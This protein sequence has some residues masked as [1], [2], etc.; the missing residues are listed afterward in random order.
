MAGRG[1]RVWAGRVAGVLAAVLAVSSVQAVVSTTGT[2]PASKASAAPAPEP[3][4][5]RPDEASAVL[6]A[7]HEGHRVEVT[8]ERTESS[9]VFANPDGTL[10]AEVASGP[11]RVRQGDSWAPVDTTL[12]VSGGQVVAAAVP[13]GLS[14]STGGSGPV[15]SLSRAGKAFGLTWPGSLGAPVVKGNTATYPDVAPGTDLVVSVLPSGVEVSF[16]LRTRP[17]GPVSLGFGVTSP[18]LTVGV[19]ASGGFTAKDDGGAVV[20]GGPPPAM[21]GADADRAA[22]SAG[23]VRPVDQEL[24]TSLSGT[25]VT[26]TPDWGFLSDPSTVYPVTVDPL[27]GFSFFWDTFVW[28]GASGTNFEGSQ[29]FR[30]GSPDG[31]TTQRALLRFGLP[32]SLTGAH[33]LDADLRVYQEQAGSCT[34]TTANVRMIGASWNPSTVTWSSQPTVLPGVYDPTSF[35]HGFDASCASAWQDIH[36]PDVVNQWLNGGVTNNGLELWAGN[37][38]DASARKIFR[39]SE[40]GG[41]TTY[42]PALVATYNLY[43]GTVAGRSTEPSTIF[44]TT[45]YTTSA[46][47]T[48]R[49]GSVDGDG[50][51]TRVDY[52]IWNSTGTTKIA[53]GSTPFAQQGSLLGW[54]PATPLAD[55]AYEWRARG[56][57]GTD[58]SKNWSSWV[59]FTV[60]TVHPATPV[61][62]STDYT[63]GVWKGANP[64][65]TFTLSD[66]STDLDH[67]VYS[68]DRSTPSITTASP[69]VITPGDGWRT[70]SVQ[71]VDKAGNLSV[72]ATYSFGTIPGLTS[73]AKGT[74]TQGSLQLSS[75]AAPG[76][77]SV[78]YNW[79]RSPSDAWAPI[80]AADVTLGG[81]G[82]GSWPV[83]FSSGSGDSI[84][85]DLVWHVAASLSDQDGPVQVQVCFDTGCSAIPVDATLDEA[86][87][88]DAYATDG[89]GPGTLSLLTGNLAV[90]ETDVSVPAY[91]TTLTVGRTFNTRAPASPVSGV[92]GPGWTAA[93]PVDEAGS[94][95]SG[96]S[97]TGTAVTLTGSDGSITSFAKTGAT[98]TPTGDDADSGITLTASGGNANGPTTFTL[99]DLDG[100]STNFTAAS[101]ASPPSLTNP[102]SYAVA[103]VSQPGSNQTTTFTYDTSNRPTR[104]LAPIPPGGTCTDPASAATWT[105]GCRALTFGYDTNS[106]LTAVTLVTNPGSSVLQVD[107]ACYSYDGNG[108]LAQAW[109]P[110]DGAAG[111]GSHPVACGSPVLAT[112][113]GYDTGTGRLTTVTPP[114][115]AAW[116]LGYDGTGRVITAS[117]THNATFGG[118]T[119]T[120]TAVYGISIQADGTNPD[121][122]PG[123]LGADVAGWAQTDA[124]V[125][126]T[127]IYTPGDT[128]SATDLRDGQVHYLDVNGREVN[129]ASYSGTGATGWHI[130]TTEYGPTGNTLRSLTATNR[131]EAL[132]PTAG[133]GADLGLP[134]DTAAA[135]MALS[136]VNTYVTAADGTADLTDTWGPYHTVTLADGDHVGARAHTHNTYDTGSEVGHPVGPTLHLVTSTTTAASLSIDT[137][138]TDERDTR[139]TDTFYALSATD[140]TGWTFRQPMK[141]VEDPTGLAKTSITRYDATTGA[142]IESR[143]P[144]NT[145]G[146]GAG[147]TLSIY[148]TAG[149][150]TQDAACGNKPAWINLLCET[151]PAAQPGVAGLPGL[152]TSRTSTY[153]Y[154]NRSTQVDEIVTDAVGAT[155]TRT[156]TTTYLNSGYGDRVVTTTV[157]DGLGA[158]VPTTTTDYDPATG[159]AT[160]VSASAT[161]ENAATSATTGYDD[162]GRTITYVDADEAT[163]AARNQT[164]T[165]YDTAGRVHQV[166]DAHTTLTYTYNGGTE[167]RGLTTSLAVAV[168]SATP[169]TGTYTAV[170]DPDGQ[171]SSQTDPKGIRTDLVRDETGALNTLTAINTADGSTWMTDQI[172]GTTIHGQ[173]TGDAGPAGSHAY[174][175]DALGRLTQADDT[176][177]GATCI[178]RVY[179]FDADTN[180][181]TSTAYPAGTDGACQGDTGGVATT[182]TYDTAD[183]LQPAGVDTGLAYDAFGRTTT[184]PGYGGA[185]GTDPTTIDYYAGDLVR[186]ETQGATIR[187]WGLDADGRFG[188][189]T[190]TVSGSTTATKTNHYDDGS[191]DSPDWIAENADASQWTA[192]ISD[193]LS[194]LGLTVDQAG[195][196]T[197]QYANLHGDI[198]CT[199]TPTDTTPVIGPDYDEYGNPSDQTTRRYG[200]L[201]G[202]QRSGDSLA[203]LILMGVRL[204]NPTL[205]RFLSTDPVPGGSANPY[206]YCN[207][208]PI[209]CIDLDG[210]FSLRGWAWKHKWDIAATAV[211]FTG[212]GGAVWAFRAYRVYRGIRSANKSYRAA[213]YATRGFGV[214]SR[215]R[216]TFTAGKNFGVPAR[217]FVYHYAKH[218]ARYGSP[219]RYLR[220][221]EQSLSRVRG[222][223]KARH[224]GSPGGIL[225]DARTHWHS[226]W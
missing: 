141:T 143:M 96:L 136:T 11:V 16:V 117:R 185:G 176:P 13:Y 44:G 104:V 60:D 53:S 102:H 3:V 225:N 61:I 173:D 139:R 58:F 67:Y 99:S 134:S 184:L 79:R 200:W 41:T 158:A 118:G 135:A 127:A 169:Y 194:G 15:A 163:G 32:A 131:E 208:D 187:V 196:V 212:V 18:G 213:L 94:D 155:V 87:F 119:E 150:N 122:R 146:G 92:F 215:I 207:A 189:W 160:T 80:P 57:D 137:V 27:Y 54:S 33:I 147:T 46:T 71:A 64:Q 154:L 4:T 26:L 9:T 73:P 88:G 55:G 103:L 151:T 47:P 84:P 101:F 222:S 210:K 178:R 89:F 171:A 125:T 98:Y 75:R 76:G 175:Y 170:Y 86:A 74:K 19:D 198:T 69:L 130:T 85:P 224:R 106:H 186:S 21:W 132:N 124:P 51:A 66:T 56:Y 201:G 167:H 116:T 39:S 164:T 14:L 6:A 183:R 29:W 62:T 203:G 7:A 219:S 49:G 114:G 174:T 182:H 145:A 109:D 206:D 100:D 28:N 10:T 91:N 126:A 129:T 133:A 38:T 216:N 180:R 211:S 5:E 157:T 20:V 108:R 161:A 37:E 112:S 8:G 43:P 90:N 166:A 190:D 177:V 199:A 50:G 128:V 52:E 159:L 192:N 111:T 188:T 35:A 48:L 115:Q 179:V 63:A 12:R 42:T 78:T 97:D 93:L 25:G 40:Y 165:S 82:I 113:Y 156:T 121:Y 217:S 221:A 120:T 36:V 31:S 81:V 95:Y 123:M 149:T 68:I 107:T 70:L 34:P 138:A 202:K 226:F 83:T 168:N 1:R 148:Y 153:D 162:F 23:G 24:T 209:N 195:T 204:Y 65:G 77:S 144:S 193:L 172:T 142:T 17:A 181:T 214:A 140:A 72:T 218:G 59:P 205:G 22:G 223:V 110:R 2:R 220:A 45:T 30:A 197:Y 191:E 152:V 105:A